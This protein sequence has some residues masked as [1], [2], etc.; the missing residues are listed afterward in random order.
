M[1]ENERGSL[2]LTEKEVV[3]MNRTRWLFRTFRALLFNE[4]LLSDFSICEA[5]STLSSA[6]PGDD[7]QKS[8]TSH[9]HTG[10][11]IDGVASGRIP[12]R[13]PRARCCDLRT[14]VSNR[15]YHGSTRTSYQ[16]GPP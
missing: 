16:Q 3:K 5:R 4:D 8:E 1:F 12:V 14:T 7:K 15:S 9:H 2:D 11:R 6:E 10:E 13:R